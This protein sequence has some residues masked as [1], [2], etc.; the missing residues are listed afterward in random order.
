MKSYADSDPSTTVRIPIPTVGVLPEPSA[1]LS[2]DSVA[3]SPSVKRGLA[4]KIDYFRKLISKWHWNRSVGLLGLVF[5]M[6]GW[7][8]GDGANSAANPLDG[9]QWH[10]NPSNSHR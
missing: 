5:L 1:H 2:L 6:L 3:T 8:G 10:K 9:C 7:G 4:T